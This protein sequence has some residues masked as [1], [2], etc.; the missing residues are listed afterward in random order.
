VFFLSLIFTPNLGELIWFKF[1]EDKDK[2]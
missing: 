1:L 2:P